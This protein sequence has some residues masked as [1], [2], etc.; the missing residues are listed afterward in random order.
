MK[1]SL[2]AMLLLA[3][4]LLIPSLA[5]AAPI[6]AFVTEFNVTPP[7]TGGL[8]SSLQILL[9]SRIASEEISL[10]SA[11]V[12]ADVIVT[13]SYTQIGKVFSL[14]AVARL[15]SGKTVASAFEQGES[16]DDLIPALGRISARLRGEIVK[17]V[18]AR[19]VAPARAVL[20]PAPAREP[21]SE[22]VR[23]EFPKGSTSE[24]I[25]G[26]QVSLAPVGPK[27][28]LITDGDTLRLYRQGDKLKPVAEA[29]LSVRLKAL[30]VDTVTDEAGKTLA[31]LSVIDSEVPASRIYAVAN[32]KLQLVAENLPYL[33]RS[34]ALNGGPKRLYAQEMGRTEDYYGDVFEASFADGSVKL[35]NPIKMP[36]YGNIFNFNTFRDAAGKT[37]TTVFSETGYLLVYNDQGEEIWRSSDK[38]GGSETYFQRR[39]K[40]SERLTAN[41]FRTRFIDQRI[42]VTDQGEVMVPQN[43]GFLVLGNQRSY[44]KYSVITFVWNGSSLEERWRTKLNQNYLSDFYFDAKTRDLVL[45]EVVQ[46]SGLFGKGGSA[47]RVIRAE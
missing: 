2:G 10:T 42:G 24:R 34:V 38:F 18:Q 37:L 43:S 5:T 22:I 4:A 27:E 36:R 8:K 19:E 32:D 9:S 25:D 16:L 47:V 46:K 1:R 11:T 35:K 31:Y 14:D 21:S 15:A 26:A 3:C 6:K 30:A 29:K 12:D 17:G 13:G 33:F 39:D 20:A 7:E 41:P 45:L 44:S 28:Y 23:Q 40:E